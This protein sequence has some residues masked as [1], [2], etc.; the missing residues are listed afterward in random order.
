MGATVYFSCCGAQPLV[1]Q[2]LSGCGSQLYLAHR[3]TTCGTWALVLRGSGT[4]PDQGSNLSLLHWQTDS[5]PLS[6]QG[7]PSH[8]F[9]ENDPISAVLGVKQRWIRN[10]ISTDLTKEKPRRMINTSLKTR[11]S[12]QNVSCFIM[13]PIKVIVHHWVSYRILRVISLMGAVPWST[14]K[15]KKNGIIKFLWSN[16]SFLT[17]VPTPMRVSPWTLSSGLFCPKKEQFQIL[18][19]SPYLEKR[20]SFCL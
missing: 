7:S 11:W 2:G 13:S 20:K 19:W 15:K 17:N 12:C 8:E 16:V 14:R 3:L 10:F 18:R 4:F 1:R 6:H 5:L 9:Y